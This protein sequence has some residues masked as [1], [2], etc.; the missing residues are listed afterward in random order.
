[1][2]PIRPPVPASQWDRVYGNNDGH[3]S[4]DERG[5]ALTTETVRERHPELNVDIRTE[6]PRDPTAPFRAGGTY[7]DEFGATNVRIYPGAVG[8]SSNLVPYI[9]GHELGHVVLNHLDRGPSKQVELEAEWFAGRTLAQF[10]EDLE[11]VIAELTAQ[12]GNADTHG[13]ISERMA[14][15]R[16]GY[17]EALAELQAGPVPPAVVPRVVPADPAPA[18]APGNVTARDPIVAALEELLSALGGNR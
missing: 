6:L 18:A 13:A 5:V 15:I 14:A 11:Q 4:L 17:A 3:L 1:M 10:G 7:R 9:T 12:G 8:A 16:G 2:P